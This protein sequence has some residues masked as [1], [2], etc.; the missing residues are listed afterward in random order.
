MN[1][2]APENPREKALCLFLLSILLKTVFSEHK[3][4]LFYDCAQLMFVSRHVISVLHE[5]KCCGLD[6]YRHTVRKSVQ[7]AGQSAR[8]TSRYYHRGE[9]NQAD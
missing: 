7:Y 6:V 8:F 4:G 1:D 5:R 2:R 3:T 9:A